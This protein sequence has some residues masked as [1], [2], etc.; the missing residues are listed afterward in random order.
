MAIVLLSAAFSILL[1][2]MPAVAA[3]DTEALRIECALKMSIYTSLDFV[4][5]IFSH[6][7]MVQEVTTL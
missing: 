2:V 5:V 1:V 7:A 3:V 6:L 4:S